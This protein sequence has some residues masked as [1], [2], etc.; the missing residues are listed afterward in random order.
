MALNEV[1]MQP[2]SEIS[3]ELARREHIPSLGYRV[4]P[5]GEARLS[6]VEKCR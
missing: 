2:K 1:Q 4:L 3:K 6:K 5:L